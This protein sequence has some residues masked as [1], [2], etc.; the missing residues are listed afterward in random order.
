MGT[1]R[2]EL[3][4]SEW[5][6][7]SKYFSEKEA[8]TPGRPPKPPRPKLNGVIWLTRSGAPWRD[9]PDR[10]GSWNTVYDFFRELVDSGVLVKIF[11]DLNID[12]DLQDM[13]ID[14]TTA[15]VHQHGCGAKKGAT[16]PK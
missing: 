7:V 5:E 3:T 9:M 2:Y 11:A 6:R 16:P 10:Y 15:R 14:S 8:G 4:D 13:S 1:K 12:A